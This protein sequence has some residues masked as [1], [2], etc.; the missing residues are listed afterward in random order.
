MGV[1]LTDTGCAQHLMPPTGKAIPIGSSDSGPAVRAERGGGVVVVEEP[2]DGWPFRWLSRDAPGGY[3]TARLPAACVACAVTLV[4]LR[5]R[6]SFILA[7]SP[8]VMRPY[9]FKYA[10]LDSVT[11]V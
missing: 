4:L 5:P 2:L 7:S 1:I 6:I 10:E 9:Q 3:D 8:F 11:G